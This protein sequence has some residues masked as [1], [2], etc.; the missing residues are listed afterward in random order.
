M[1]QAGMRI[2]SGKGQDPP[3]SLEFRRA[4]SEQNMVGRSKSFSGVRVSPQDRPVFSHHPQ[5]S[6]KVL[7][8]VKLFIASITPSL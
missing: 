1:D 5:G 6:E 4:R 7:T 3:T 2:K 8:L